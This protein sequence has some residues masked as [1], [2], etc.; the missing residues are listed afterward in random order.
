M[1][2]TKVA[3]PGFERETEILVARALTSVATEA[4]FKFTF[5]FKKKSPWLRTTNYL[6]HSNMQWQL[7][8]NSCNCTLYLLIF[9]CWWLIKFDALDVKQ[10]ISIFQSFS[11]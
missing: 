7:I 2:L 10:Q 6:I 11:W 1:Q 9:D 8:K 4:D 3:P 5:I